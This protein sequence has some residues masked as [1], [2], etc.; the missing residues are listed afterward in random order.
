MYNKDTIDMIIIFCIILYI[1]VRICYFSVYP[2]TLNVNPSLPPIEDMINLSKASSSSNPSGGGNN[3]NNIN[4]G[5]IAADQD[6][7]RKNTNLSDV[8]NNPSLGVSPVFGPPLADL[9]T[10][11]PP[12]ANTPIV[13]PPAVNSFQSSG[14]IY[15]TFVHRK[16]AYENKDY[17][18]LHNVYMYDKDH[19]RYCLG[20]LKRGP[21]SNCVVEDRDL[22]FWEKHFKGYKRF[23]VLVLENNDYQLR[24]INKYTGVSIPNILTPNDRLSTN[25]SKRPIILPDGNLFIRGPRKH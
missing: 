21:L 4:S 14:Y 11:N 10:L 18:T 2:Y 16:D 13:N 7:N 17:I 25:A 8:L 3:S 15:G 24:T 12:L 19:V 5:N 1:F 20:T 23:P 22:Y 9:P 6:N